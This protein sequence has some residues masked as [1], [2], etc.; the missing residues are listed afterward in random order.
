MNCKLKSALF[1]FCLLALTAVFVSASQTC[2]FCKR[3][4][5]NAGFLYSYSYCKDYQGAETCFENVYNYIIPWALCLEDLTEGWTLDINND[6]KADTAVAGKC[7][8][9]ESSEGYNGVYV[10]ATVN[11][12]SN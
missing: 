4:D 10:N 5:L 11:L 2:L 3:A 9:F 12:K 8:N 1:T 7:K 6:C